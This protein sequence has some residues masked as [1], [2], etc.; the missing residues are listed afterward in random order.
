MNNG[1]QNLTENDQ[2]LSAKSLDETNNKNKISKG[3]IFA[4]LAALLYAL[5]IPLSKVMLNSLSPYFMAGFFY[6]DVLKRNILQKR[7]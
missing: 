6:F 3:I 4:L 5:N 7:Q 2:E 1:E